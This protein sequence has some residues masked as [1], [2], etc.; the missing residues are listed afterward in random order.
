MPFSILLQGYPT[1][2]I[3]V[4]HVQGPSVQGMFLHLLQEVDPAVNQRLHD[5][6]RYRPYTLSPLGI[7]TRHNSFQG[8]YLPRQQMLA[9][10][11]P[12]YLRI[13]LLDDAL[14]PTFRQYFL[15]RSEP[16]FR[17]GETEFVVTGILE[18]P[19][20]AN[21]P[22]WTQYRSYDE[23]I[24]RASQHRSMTLHFLTPTSFGHG[25]VDVPLPV[26]R[27]VFQ[28][29]LKRFQEFCASPFLP[30][31]LEQI[32]LYVGVAQIEHL[33]TEM[34]KTKRIML[35]GFL[36]EVRFEISKKASPTL[37]SQIQ[38][39]ADFAFFGGTGKKTTVGMGQTAR[40]A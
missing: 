36:G 17:L 10:K 24:N 22:Q 35:Q 26:P 16:T 7:G 30:D 14:F 3:P 37:V 1:S 11:T 19:P 2:D 29:Y 4:A 40:I 9:R 38:L 12:C 34:I 18:T 25:D 28:S 32:D 27:L 31:V 20:H 6:S 13:T 39:L 8:F 23:L 33:R 15:E 5:D 21:A